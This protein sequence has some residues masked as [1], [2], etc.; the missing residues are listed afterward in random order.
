MTN[1]FVSFFILT[2]FILGL[3]VTPAWSSDDETVANELTTLLKA[4][5]AVLVQNKPLIKNPKKA[6]ID[7]N[8][9]LA[10]TYKNYE[11][12]TGKKFKKDS[13]NV[14]EA[15]DKLIQAIE[16]VVDDVVSGK[17]TA[18]DRRDVFYRLFLPGKRRPSSVRFR[19]VK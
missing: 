10:I 1:K 7:A 11:K 15:Q 9:F 19:G 5:R 3:G 6:G 14:G 2:I 12:A 16:Q 8:K 4:S 17:D 18:L 13:G